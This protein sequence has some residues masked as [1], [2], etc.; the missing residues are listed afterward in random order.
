MA[1]DER[2]YAEQMDAAREALR[3]GRPADAERLLGAALETAER[4][5]GADHPSLATALAGLGQVKRALGDDAAAERLFRD[6]L[7]IRERALAPQH[8]GTVVTMEQ[9]AETCATRGNVSEAVSLLQRALPTREAALGADHATVRALRTRIAE[10]ELRVLA[11][12]L[13]STEPQIASWMRT[14]ASAKP[15]IPAASASTVAELSA[16]EPAPVPAAPVASGHIEPSRRPRRKRLVLLAFAGVA[17]VALAT[18]GMTARSRADAADVHAS[19]NAGAETNAAPDGASSVATMGVALPGPSRSD[20]L[21]STGIVQ[22]GT[23]MPD[24]AAPTTPRLPR[25]PKD[26]AALTARLVAGTNVD[27]M[28]RATTLDRTLSL[29]KNGIGPGLVTS[30]HMDD[31]SARPAAL[32]APAPLPRFPDELR[33]KWTESEVVVRFRV[34]ERGRVDVAS[35][36]VLKSDHELFTAA[37]REVL[38]RFRFDPARSAAP[39]SRPISDWVDYRVRFAAVK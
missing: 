2:T 15:A 30:S 22:A 26:L 27:S 8:M 38:P 19:A 25:V 7:R 4:R 13:A 16:P 18:V 20:S 36:K 6:A 29:D 32:V 1:D 23:P 11:S 39:E 28:V 24:S 17:S 34:D 12:T 5:Y 21:S 10:L 31:A 35:L 33:S 3:Q 37:V 14:D 9:L